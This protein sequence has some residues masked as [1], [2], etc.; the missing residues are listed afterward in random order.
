MRTVRCSYSVCSMVSAAWDFGLAA[1]TSVASALM[2]VL[3]HEDSLGPALFVFLCLAFLANVLAGQARLHAAEAEQRRVEAN[4]AAELA[5][6]TLQAQDLDSALAVAGHRVAQVISLAFADLV[7]FESRGDDSRLAI[8]LRDGE[9]QLGTLVVPA[10]SVRQTT[11]ASA[12]HDAVPRG[13]CRSDARSVEDQRRS[14]CPRK[15]AGRATPGGHTG[16]T[17]G[18]TGRRVPSGSSGACE[19]AGRQN[20]P[21]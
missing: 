3:F 10:E 13:I 4:L 17:R 9:E 18:G 15:A 2:Y 12:A 7:L 20:M 16:R 6:T 21:R 14:Q 1:A 5:R 11:G 8:P 19:R